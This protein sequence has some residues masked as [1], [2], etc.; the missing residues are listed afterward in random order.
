MKYP[1]FGKVCD[2]MRNVVAVKQPY[3]STH[4][5]EGD[6]PDTTTGPETAEIACCVIGYA[7][8]VDDICDDVGI[9]RIADELALADPQVF[10]G[11][12]QLYDALQN[13]IGAAIADSIF[14]GATGNRYESFL[15]IPLRFR[16]LLKCE[17]PH[18]VESRPW[19]ED[20]LEYMLAVQYILENIELNVKPAGVDY[21]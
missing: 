2:V 8:L 16:S 12:F 21:E 9:P 14:A 11:C 10:H 1:L 3:V 4:Y 17:F 20:A 7:R 19:A 6:L 15:K 13:E 18:L 5:Y